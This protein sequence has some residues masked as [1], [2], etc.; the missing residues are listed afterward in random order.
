MTIKELIKSLG[1]Y[2]DEATAYAYEGEGFVGIVVVD[3][4]GKGLGDISARQPDY[5]PTYRETNKL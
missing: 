3:E 2:P 1:K 4:N 5:K